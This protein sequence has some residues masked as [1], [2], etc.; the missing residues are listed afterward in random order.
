MSRVIRGDDREDL[1]AE[2]RRRT[3]SR[4]EQR[5]LE[6]ALE[7]SQTLRVAHRV[8]TDFDAHTRVQ[9][10]DEELILRAADAALAR[11]AANVSGDESRSGTA[12]RSIVPLSKAS[13]RRRTAGAAVG[14]AFVLTATGLAAAYWI[15]VPT[16]PWMPNR[17]EAKGPSSAPALRTRSNGPPEQLRGDALRP[18]ARATAEA[19]VGPVEPALRPSQ[20]PVRPAPAET[21][22]ELFQLANA[23]RRNDD[24]PRARALYSELISRYPT[25]DEA[26][27]AQ[28]SLGKL[29]LSAGDPARAERAFNRYLSA[30]RGQLAEEALVNRAQSL[31]K[32]NQSEEERRVWSRL[33]AEFPNSV[34]AT[35]ARE[36]L[37]ALDPNSH[38]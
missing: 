29:Y 32:L 27:L 30:G 38:P 9:A 18:A 13:R 26:R 28:V 3:L 21:A 12:P 33:L 16:L 4:A 22:A 8:G 14:F 37:R 20:T 36:R 17:P 10:G 24:F 1:S 2:A 15:G 23:A 5:E 7:A 31:R 25:S 6:R 35:Q 11:V 34:Y 19:L